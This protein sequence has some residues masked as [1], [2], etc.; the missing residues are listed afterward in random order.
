MKDKY[1]YASTFLQGLQVI[2]LQQAVLEYGQTDASTFA[3]SVTTE[4]DG[5]AMDT[6]VNTIPLP[7]A[8]GGSATMFDL[9][10]DDFVLAGG[11]GASA[12]TQT[13]LVAT[14]QLPFVVADPTQGGLPAVHYP[15]ADS[16]GATLNK[17]PVQLSSADGETVYQ[18]CNGRAVALGTVPVTDNAG[19]S[20]NK[21]VAVVVGSGAVGPAASTN[22]FATTPPPSVPVLAVVDMT[23]AYD[24]AVAYTPV[25]LGFLQ[26]PTG[27]TDVTLNGSVALV[28]T[29]TNILLVNLEKPAHPTLAGQITGNFGNWLA[30]TQSGFLV[31]T[32]PNSASGGIQTAALGAIA[33]IHYITPHVSLDSN[34][35]TKAPIDVSYEFLGDTGS[36]TTGRLNIEQDG[37][38]VGTIPLPDVSPGVHTLSIPVGTVLYPVPDEIEAAIV[39]PDGTLTSS[40]VTSLGPMPSDAI[41]GSNPTPPPAPA[42]VIPPSPTPGVSFVGIAALSS[43]ILTPD[44]LSTGQGDTTIQMSAS[45]FDTLSSIYVRRLD[46]VW[47]RLSTSSLAQDQTTFILPAALSSSP[48]FLELSLGGTDGEPSIPLPVADPS[49]PQL[50]TAPQL[51]PN[52]VFLNLPDAQGN[53]GVTAF[54][55]LL[56]SGMKIVLGQGQT[57]VTSLPSDALS[58]GSLTAT[59]PSRLAYIS[60]PSIFIAILSSDGTKLSSFVCLPALLDALALDRSSGRD[61]SYPLNAAAAFSPGDLQLTS[62]NR[63]PGSADPASGRLTQVELQGVGLVA[64]QTV[65][66]TVARSAQPFNRHNLVNR[67]SRHYA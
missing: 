61:V 7:L 51:T 34:S 19:N 42:L 63:N 31:S 47:V 26:L 21:H 35:A 49:L 62:G 59:Q 27:P 14:G 37:K 29:G 54:N 64:S 3:Q 48:G 66:F 46:G 55:P 40:F 50:G 65:Q 6:I 15:P 5:F 36:L 17:V 23:Q 18:L 45:G 41:P 12:A 24:P 28:A 30:L 38:D 11:S 25:P 52:S 53:P 8:A 1:L 9:K 57:A 22:C 33:I 13:L 60:G 10:A 44:H 58:A 2:D 43:V 56:V 39:R 4:G 16:T 32:S 67:R 20:A